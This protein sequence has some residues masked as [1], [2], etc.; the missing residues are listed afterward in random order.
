MRRVLYILLGMAAILTTA[1]NDIDDSNIPAPSM[2]EGS[3]TLTIVAGDGAT[4]ATT[5]GDGTLNTGGGMQDVTVVLIDPAG[6]RESVVKTG[7]TGE[8]ALRTSVEFDELHIGN[9]TLL[10]FANL[11]GGSA[12]AADINGKLNTITAATLF[13]N[14]SGTNVP[15][16]GADTSKPMVLTATQNIAVGVGTNSTTVELLRPVALFEMEFHNHSNEYDLGID[17]LTFSS[18]N[19]T[20]SYVS[21]HGETFSTG[22][23]RSLPAYGGGVTV[24]KSGSVVAYS[25]YI[26]ENAAPSYTFSTK[27]TLQGAV[28]SPSQVAASATTIANVSSSKTYVIKQSG[29]NRYLAANGN[30]SLTTT[31]NTNLTANTAAHWKIVKNGTSTFTIQNV[32]NGMYLRLRNDNTNNATLNSSSQNFEYDSYNGNKYI[33]YKYTTTGAWGGTY[34]SYSHLRYNNGVT[35]TDNSTYAT[36]WEFYEVIPGFSSSKTVSNKPIQIVDMGTGDV[37]PLK[38]MKRNQHV[39]VIVNVFVQEKEGQ[40]N[41]QLSPVWQSADAEHT[42]GQ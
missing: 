17:N 7:L 14:L 33:A 18:F 16:S 36:Q 31:T 26:Y 3:L 8:D 4:R 39:K 25:T 34:T 22:A 2:G 5:P 28:S 12:L 21:S 10:A 42:F 40:F 19:P 38:M 15:I 11:T 23:Y 29:Q 35:A 27:V 1:C 6:A 32:S 24:P 30:T 41:F 20:T 37:E 13:A 9:Y